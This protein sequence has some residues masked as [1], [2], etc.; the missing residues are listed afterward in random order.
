MLLFVLAMDW[1]SP[2]T[3]AREDGAKVAL[4]G[5]QVSREKKSFI[6]HRFNRDD[7]K[8]A[9]SAVAVSYTHLTLPTN[10]AV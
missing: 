4:Y 10:I 2:D 7:L 3:E 1:M 8:M 6:R 5:H 9:E